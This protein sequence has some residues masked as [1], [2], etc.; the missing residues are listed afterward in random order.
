MDI[1]DRLKG[2]KVPVN[3][4][5]DEELFK[6]L[7]KLR[8]RENIKTLSPVINEILWKWINAREGN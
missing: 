5:I 7:K 8:E 4:T 6:R 1:L 2:K 3:I